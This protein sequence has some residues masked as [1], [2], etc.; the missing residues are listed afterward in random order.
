MNK[1][2][3]SPF[4][5]NNFIKF[6][7]KYFKA[8]T[9]NAG[10]KKYN[11]DLLIIVFNKL[12]KQSAVYTKSSTPA[13]P[14]IWNKNIIHNLCKVLIVNSGNANAFTGKKG[15]NQIK[16]YAEVASKVF[17]CD[18][19]QV[20]IASTGIIGEQLNSNLIIAKL[21]IIKNSK[22]KNILNAAKA[23]M[24]T[25]TYPKIASTIVNTKKQKIKIFGIAK[26]SG[27]IA[28]RMGTM[29]SYIFI[30]IPLSEKELNKILK[31]NIEETFNSI[32]VD[33]DTSTNDTVM[34]FALNDTK[35]LSQKNF[36]LIKLISLGVRKV[37]LNL[38]KKIICD[39]EGISKLI[40][41][42]VINAKSKSQASKLAFSIAES[43]LVKTAIYGED[44]NWGR[45]IMAIGKAKVS[46]KID[47]NKLILKF[48][49]F[50][51]AENGMMSNRINISKLNKYMKNKIIK[52]NLNLNLGKNKRTVW[53]SDLSD[54]YIKINADYSS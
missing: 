52:I 37:M 30:D 22:S 21:R 5:P 50:I 48:G 27:M 18:L 3:I 13:A 54:K 46:E 7:S 32:S 23:I 44:P 15:L 16:K 14:I 33:G 41:V 17:D 11:D 6:K 26:G 43:I 53:S 35:T 19:D 36:K 25:D 20:F 24:T 29:L 28:P 47:Q 1:N 38:C 45:I 10:F 42:N 51:V 8:Y 4:K 39:G 40:E 34:L 12:V 9:F 49:N 31:D 2:Y